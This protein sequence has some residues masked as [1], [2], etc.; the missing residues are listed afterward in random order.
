[1]TGKREKTSW[2][3]KILFKKQQ[4]IQS[5]I[6]EYLN[7]VSEVQDTFIKAFN[8]YF[9]KGL[10]T[11][12]DFLTERTHKAESKC[13]DIKN[14]IE[15]EMYAKALIPESRGDIMELLEAADKIPNQYELVLYMIRTQRIILP[16]FMLAD[17]KEL[18][19][20]SIASWHLLKESI[21]SLFYEPDRVQELSALID[22]KESQGDHIERKLIT[23]IFESDIND[24]HKMLLKDL[25]IQMGNIADDT[26]EASRKVSI[27]SVKRRV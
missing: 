3:K 11:E 9:D 18:L 5:L 6:F 12:F 24:L 10:C 14:E 16:E 7:K 26:D 21:E 4:Y 13:D 8:V 27:I 17:T 19:D 20:V 15:F 23:A 22:Q 1:M 2:F 25:V